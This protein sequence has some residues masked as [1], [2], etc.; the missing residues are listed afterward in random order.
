MPSKKAKTQKKKQ[1]TQSNAPKKIGVQKSAV[2]LFATVAVICVFATIAAFYLTRNVRVYDFIDVP[3]N[4]SV[5]PPMQVG[6][7]ALKNASILFFGSVPAGGR[8]YKE[9]SII[10]NENFPLLI[11]ITILGEAS[12]FVMPGN[13]SIKILP[14]ES[15]LIPFVAEIPWNETVRQINGTARVAF[16][17]I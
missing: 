3:I 16:I 7:G 14:G 4:L 12:S 6:I 1:K 2:I 10:N 17:K 13:N 9:I 8:G 5:A 11:E 15:K